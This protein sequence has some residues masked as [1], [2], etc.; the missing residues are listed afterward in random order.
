MRAYPLLDSPP[1]WGPTIRERRLDE[2]LQVANLTADEIRATVRPPLPQV[3]LFP[4]RTGYPSY[5]ARQ[6]RVTDVIQVD[7]IYGDVWR[8]NWTG[9]PGGYSGTSRP[10]LGEF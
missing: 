9:T 3:Q 10:S 1:R 6:A 4:P 5:A 7:R 8:I 2:A